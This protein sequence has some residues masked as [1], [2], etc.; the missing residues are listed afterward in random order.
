MTRGKINILDIPIDHLTMIETVKRIDD[1]IKNNQ[2][3]IHSVV[4]SNKILLMRDDDFVRKSVLESDI[5]SADGQS[6][7]WASR[8]L[9][10]PLPERVT[11]IDLMQNLI[12]LAAEKKYKVFLLGAKEGVVSKLAKIYS[13]KY[14]SDIIA[15]YS[16][17]YYTD[18]EERSIA[19][20]ISKS[21]ADML[22]IGIESPKKEYFIIRNKKILKNVNFIMGVGGSFD[23]IAGLRKRAPRTFQKLGL[24]W[25]YRFLQEPRRLWKRYLLGNSRFIYIV[26]RKKIT[27]LFIR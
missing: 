12:T 22:F 5:I 16:N 19:D 13:K 23:V 21:G 20:K 8:F 17:G 18:D 15:G 14:S 7:V 11:G 3:I 6:V 4:N 27:S 10:S 1:A 2:Q 25:L 9:K 26:I 24:E